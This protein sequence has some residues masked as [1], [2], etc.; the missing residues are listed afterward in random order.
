MRARTPLGHGSAGSRYVGR[1]DDAQG[2]RIDVAVF[3]R[4]VVGREVFAGVAADAPDVVDLPLAV[5]LYDGL[6]RANGGGV[7]EAPCPG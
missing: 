7:G 5:A 2:D 6:G 1:L 3:D 4:D